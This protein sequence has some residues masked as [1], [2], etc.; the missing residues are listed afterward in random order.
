MIAFPSIRCPI[1]RR[2]KAIGASIAD[3]DFLIVKKIRHSFITV[4]HLMAEQLLA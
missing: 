3:L 4:V 2:K 1:G